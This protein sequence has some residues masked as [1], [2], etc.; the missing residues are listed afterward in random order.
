MKKVLITGANSYIGTSVEKWLSQFE[1]QYLVDTL[2]MLDSNWMNYDFSYYDA[3]FHVAG[4]VHKN[5]K[6]I[7]PD[8]YYKV[9]RDLTHK[10]AKLAK[11]S[12]V[13]QFIFLSTMSVY[14]SDEKIITKETEEKPQNHYGKSKL[15][16]EYLLKELCS[17]QFQVAIVRPPMVYGK[18]SKGNYSKLSKLSKWTLVFPNIDNQRSMIFIDNLSEFIKQLVDMELSG[19]YFPQNSEYISTR[20]MVVSIRRY[21]K[22]HTFLTSIIN[23]MIYK[24]R[25]IS[26]VNKLFGNLIYEKSMSEYCFEYQ[27][28]NFEESIILTERE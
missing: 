18:D 10:L 2:D 11:K 27:I 16:A 24:L 4:I 7:D 9:N 22:K 5:E 23:V 13:R 28:R 6:N 3:V 17:K 26:Q 20:E 12:G 8:I 25:F 19:V 1:N 15:E 14:D 21:H